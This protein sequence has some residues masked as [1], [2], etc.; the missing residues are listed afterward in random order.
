MKDTCDICGTDINIAH[1]MLISGDEFVC[2]RCYLY[3]SRSLIR[4]FHRVYP[5]ELAI[6]FSYEDKMNDGTASDAELQEHIDLL[7]QYEPL[8]NKAHAEVFLQE[9]NK[10]ERHRR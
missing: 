8:V 10:I 6:L 5:E 2:L 9:R 3:F 1:Y 4:Y 7:R